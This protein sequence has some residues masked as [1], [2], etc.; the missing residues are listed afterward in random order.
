MRAP[1]ALDRWCSL[2]LAALFGLIGGLLAFALGPGFGTLI[3]PPASVA[4]PVGDTAMALSGAYTFIHDTWRWPI[5]DFTGLSES[6]PTNAIFTDSIPLYSLLWKSAG[7]RGADSFAFFLPVWVLVLFLWQGAATGLGLRLL[8]VS[9]VLPLIAGGM[10]LALWPAF[11]HRA[12]LHIALA[13]HGFIILAVAMLLSRPETDRSLRYRIA[14]WTALLTAAV[15]VHA[16]L[17]VMALACFLL[18]G[19]VLLA[20]ARGT[21]RLRLLALGALPPVTAAVA[22]AAAGYFGGVPGD[23][24][25]FGHFRLNLAAPLMHGEGSLLPELLPIPDGHKSGYA[26]V[27][28]GGLLLLGLA[29]VLAIGGRAAPQLPRLTD[30]GTGRLLLLAGLVLLIVFATAGRFSWGA[31]DLFAVPLPEIVERVGDVLRGSGRFVWLPLYGI[32]LLALARIAEAL[33]PGRATGVIAIATALVVIE[34]APLRHALYTDPGEFSGDAPLAERIREAE[35]IAVLPAWGCD[36]LHHPGLDKEI[37]Y[38]AAMVGARMVNSMA[39]ARIERQ[40]GWQ[41]PADFL[42]DPGALL[43]LKRGGAGLGPALRVG[44]DPATCRAISGLALC[45]AAARAEPGLPSIPVHPITLPARLDFSDKLVADAHLGNGFATPE[46]WGTWTVAE[47]ATLA[48]RLAA[49]NAPFRLSLRMRGFV[50]EV[51]PTTSARVWLEGRD[52]ADQPWHPIADRHVTFRRG[53]GPQTVEFAG[54]A[55]GLLEVRL[56]ILPEAPISPAELGT[57]RDRRRLG[58]GLIVLEID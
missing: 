19:L 51:R 9:G 56:T 17:F 47:E 14:G 48:L 26:Y 38:H 12:P 46:R 39:A 49:P 1:P 33:G 55:P 30:T 7:L 23:A 54:L 37:Q 20:E 16:Y 50:P 8:G 32:A 4:A 5:F 15:L 24:G 57:G 36:P 34:M 22:M 25:G 2:G 58:V 31:V 45:G 42:S 6:H 29:I 35:R 3:M 21:A 28:L 40:C 18:Q 44:I 41:M 10:L 11:Q 53:N 43:V 27:P 13:A 52:A